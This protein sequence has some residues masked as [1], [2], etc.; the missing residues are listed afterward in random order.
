MANKAQNTEHS[1]A[2]N[3][4]TGYYGGRAEAKL[5]SKKKRREDGKKIVRKLVED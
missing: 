1:G 5:E 3:G 2:K 4:G